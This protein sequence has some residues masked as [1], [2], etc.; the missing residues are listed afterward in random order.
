LA[1]EYHKIHSSTPGKFNDYEFRVRFPAVEF[2]LQSLF[3]SFFFYYQLFVLF[4]FFYEEMFLIF[5]CAGTKSLFFFC[6]GITSFGNQK[7]YHFFLGN[8]IVINF[9]PI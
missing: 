9:Q 6:E 8:E 7:K 2:F 4:L 5:S 1:E 3:F